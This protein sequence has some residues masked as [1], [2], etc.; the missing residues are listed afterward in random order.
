MQSAPGIEKTRTHCLGEA[1]VSSSFGTDL[2]DED[3]ELTSSS[4]AATLLPSEDGPSITKWFGPPEDDPNSQASIP[5]IRSDRKR[6]NT[7]P[8]SKHEPIHLPR[9]R[10]DCCSATSPTSA[11][12]L[13]DPLHPHVSPWLDQILTASEVHWLT[14]MPL[15]SNNLAHNCR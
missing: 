9:H 5:I 3:G 1:C 14:L 12:T 6:E 4:D 10:V 15:G 8:A 7:R 2:I 11:P 13:A